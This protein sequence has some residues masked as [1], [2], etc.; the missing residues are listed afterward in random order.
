MLLAGVLVLPP[1]LAAQE[2]GED[3]PEAGN[4]EAE[5]EVEQPEIDDQVKEVIDK[6][7][8]FLAS[9]QEPDGSWGKGAPGREQYRGAMT[10]YTLVALMATGNLPGQGPYGTNAQ[11]GLDYLLGIVLPEG[12]LRTDNQ[13]HYMY[14]HGIATLVL[15]E[16]YGET[17]NP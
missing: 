6:S 2:A 3:A 16:L 10:S 5:A 11:K 7:L 9:Q 17:Q 12:Q 14:S 8:A 15:A 13:R 1:G 4:A